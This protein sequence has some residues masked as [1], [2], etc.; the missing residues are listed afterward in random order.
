MTHE[1]SPQSNL[2]QTHAQA[3]YI[4]T[5]IVALLRDESLPVRMAIQVPFRDVVTT[6]RSVGILR[7]QLLKA[8]RGRLAEAILC[9]VVVCEKDDRLWSDVLVYEM[10][11][12]E[13]DE[14]SRQRDCEIDPFAQRV[15]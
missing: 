5:D 2:Q 15:G 13:E 11:L 6:Q 7:P 12:V 10:R 14:A 4:M 1:G 8:D 3:V 9:R